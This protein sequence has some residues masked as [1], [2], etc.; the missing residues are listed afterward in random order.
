MD[1]NQVEFHNVA[2]LVPVEGLGGAVQLY[3]FPLALQTQFDQRAGKLTNRISTGCEIRLVTDST[4]VVF[5]ISSH[6]ATRVHLYQGDFHTLTTHLHP[7]CVHQSRADV[8]TRLLELPAEV[9]ARCRFKPNVIRL[10]VE[11]GPI[12]L[13]GIDTFGFACRK[14]QADEKPA[15]RWLAYGSSITQ[16]DS[17]GYVH[18]AAMRLGVDV[19]NK[20]MGGSCGVEDATMKYL[21]EDCQW[22]FATMEWGINMRQ[23]VSEEEFDR[24][25]N[26]AMDRLTATGKPVFILTSFMNNA[27]LQAS[28]DEPCQRHLKFDELLRDA[29]ARRAADHPRLKLIEGCDVLKNPGWLSSDLVHP[30]HDGHNNMGEQLANLLRP[31]LHDLL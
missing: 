27:H 7:G 20:G 10:V 2:E 14:P 22:D 26:M 13:H 3:R 5:R 23:T 28:L 19:L 8:Q 17:Y 18:Q 24:R 16:A 30:T 15:T 25:I 4:H 31:H 21:V 29:C 1:K 6:E 11:H 12:Y 9:I